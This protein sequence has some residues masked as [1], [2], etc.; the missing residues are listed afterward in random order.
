MAGGKLMVFLTGSTGYMGRRL[1]AELQRRG[2]AVTALVRKRSESKAPPGCA[3]V[4]GDALDPASYRRQVPQGCTFVH[5]VGVAHP[6]PAKVA[7]FHAIDLVSIQAAV[8]ASR[9][10]EVG[11][12]VYVSVAH[13]APVMRAYIEVRSEGE[14]L[15]RAA[16]LNATIL[17]PWYVL[18]PG[19]WWPAALAPAYWILERIPGTRESAR[20]LGLVTLA[21][22]TGALAAAVDTPCA[23]VRVWEVPE[24]KTQRSADVV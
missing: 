3:V 1:A 13:P 11:H 18:G 9:F 4:V 22:M 24:I 20:R 8:D 2:R 12:F 19:H 16:G 7:E 6:S 14:A 10:A 15:I 23:G 5:L 21:Q 17:R